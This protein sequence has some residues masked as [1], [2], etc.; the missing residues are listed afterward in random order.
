MRTRVEILKNDLWVELVLKEEKIKYNTLANKIGNLEERK[1]NHSNTFALPY[2]SENIIA[3]D[4]NV[5]SPVLM[6]ESLNKKYKARYYVKDK[7]LQKGFLVINNTIR[8][9]IN[10]NFIDEALVITDEWGK[11]TFK[12]LLHQLGENSSVFTKSVIGSNFMSVINILKSYTTDKTL[13][14]LNTPPSTCTGDDPSINGK[15]AYI[16]RYPNP[17]NSIGDKFNVDKEGVRKVDS[18]NPFQ[19]R[20]I[21]S[22]FG[23]LYIC[24]QAFGYRLRLDPGVDFE[25]LRDTYMVAKGVVEG[26]PVK[27]SLIKSS[28]PTIAESNPQWW[29]YFKHGAGEGDNEG[30]YEHFFIYPNTT[31]VMDPYGRKTGI[32]SKTPQEVGSYIP[33]HD[34]PNKREELQ[35]QKCVVLIESNPFIG[36]VIWTGKV[37][38]RAPD[39]RMSYRKI[40][41]RAVWKRSNGSTFDTILTIETEAKVEDER[42]FTVTAAK[43]QLD[44]TPVD[45]VS[46]VGL[47]L[48]LDILHEGGYWNDPPSLTEMHFVEEVL[49]QGKTDYDEYGQFLKNKTN[50]LDLA[51]DMSIKELLANTLQQQ[52]LLLTFE[53]D[54]NGVQN[55]AKLF[56][57]GA[58]RDRVSEARSG[59]P[60]KYYDWSEYHQKNVPPLWNTDYGSEYGEM[61]E[62]SLSNPFAGNVGKIQI[63][64]NITSKGFQSK[65]IPLAKNQTKGFDDISSVKAVFNT[66]PYFE[67]TLKNQGLVKCSFDKYLPGVRKQYNAELV[68]SVIDS[69]P[70][71][72]L[73]NVIYSDD[74]LPI[75]IKEWYYLV[76]VSVRCQATFLLPILVLQTLDLSKPVYIETLGGFYIIEEVEEY[77]DNLSVVKVSL[78]K[79]PLSAPEP[80]PVIDLE[81]D[82]SSGDYSNDYLN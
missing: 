6:A 9:E 82:Y 80:P 40:E 39:D 37:S 53:R 7:V 29:D 58:Y 38:R 16:T 24:C 14:V 78:I 4:I 22:L 5:F 17:L 72:L 68:T 20:P 74:F 69:D 45:A 44:N 55:I 42:N 28:T 56:T 25:L 81:K 11:I 79:L 13:K 71:P 59:I 36:N 41:A 26:T 2:V 32:A 43:E 64:T 3:L 75:G 76:D 19:S 48:R 70:L 27:D 67:Y 46:F 61:N 23:F 60:F 1:I 50:L 52:G 49:P 35:T 21:F 63:S 57:Y 54:S 12:Q 18:F 33:T 10:V 15:S 8:G 34:R 66:E 30:F 73:S 31:V 77:T 65:L 47:T 51:P 62:I